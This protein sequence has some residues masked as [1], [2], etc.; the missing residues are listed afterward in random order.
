MNS[1]FSRY[2]ALAALSAIVTLPKI[3]IASADDLGI[4]QESADA[5][6]I[7]YLEGKTPSGDNWVYR[8]G[9]LLQR[10]ADDAERYSIVGPLT[11][12]IEKNSAQVIGHRQLRH[13][14][15]LDTHS[16]WNLDGSVNGLTFILGEPIRSGVSAKVVHFLGERKNLLEA[17][18]SCDVLQGH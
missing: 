4:N 15:T 5:E 13:I 16:I 12:S 3:S 17:V 11:L 1:I 8:A 2:F 7:C 6:L 18:T 9:G 10:D 14:G